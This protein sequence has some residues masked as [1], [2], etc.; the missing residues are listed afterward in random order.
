NGWVTVS[1]RSGVG[2]DDVL[3]QLVAG[4]VHRARPAVLPREFAATQLAAARAM[5]PEPVQESFMDYHLYRYERAT[6]IADNQTK[7]LALLS[8]NMVPVR[9]EYV[10]RSND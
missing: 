4:T 10:L 2:F 7:Q 5:A 8:A 9:R 1:N 6:S 3:L